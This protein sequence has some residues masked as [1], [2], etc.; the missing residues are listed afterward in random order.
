MAKPT[1]IYFTELKMNFCQSKLKVKKQKNMLFH[2][3]FA[4]IYR[5]FPLTKQHTKPQINKGV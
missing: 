2:V 1:N 3:K 4:T 5:I